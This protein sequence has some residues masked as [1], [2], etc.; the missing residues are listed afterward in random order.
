MPAPGLEADWADNLFTSNGT[1][2]SYM[3]DELK[4]AMESLRQKTSGPISVPKIQVSTL[5]AEYQQATVRQARQAQLILGNWGNI[6]Q[7]YVHSR[8][9]RPPQ[10]GK[11]KE[12]SDAFYADELLHREH[13][14]AAI[15]APAGSGKSTL[16][17]RLT[18]L[19]ANGVTGDIIPIPIDWSQA[20]DA[21][22]A[23]SLLEIAVHDVWQQCPQEQ[24]NPLACHLQ[25]RLEQ[26]TAVALIDNWGGLRALPEELA[27]Q[28]QAAL[29]KWQ[30]LLIFGRYEPD[31]REVEVEPWILTRLNDK[32]ICR[33]VRAWPLVTGHQLDTEALLNQVLMSE[34]LRD[35]SSVPLFLDLLC[36]GST[37]RQTRLVGRW[38]L[39]N[40]ALDHL[41]AK[42]I[43]DDVEILRFRAALARLAWHGY[44]Q[45]PSA[46]VQY[47][48]DLAEIDDLWREKFGEDRKRFL[49][50]A[51][52]RGLLR[53]ASGA[54]LA[55]PHLA[56]QAALAA[57]EWLRTPDRLDTLE[58]VKSK[59]PWAEVIVFAAAR[60]GLDG[61]LTDLDQFLERLCDPGGSDILGTNWL[62]AGQ[63][64]AE[65]GEST[66]EQLD[67]V[68]IGADI[69]QHLV[70]WLSQA[71][72]FTLRDSV[73]A[74][75]PWLRTSALID[76]L[77]ESAQDRRQADLDRYEMIMALGKLG[78]DTAI[79]A[80][81]AIVLDKTERQDIRDQAVEALG[82]TR[83]AEVVSFLKQLLDDE[84]L[85]KAIVDALAIHNTPEAT[86]ALLT[87]LRDD[88]S[89]A[90]Y[91]LHKLSNP[92]LL[93]VFELAI[94]NSTQPDVHVLAAIANIGSDQAVEILKP[95]LHHEEAVIF[96]RATNLLGGMQTPSS[97]QALLEFAEDEQQPH[98]RRYAALTKLPQ[99]PGLWD[100]SRV[101]DLL[102]QPDLLQ[103]AVDDG[104][105]K[106]SEQTNDTSMAVAAG[107]ITALRRTTDTD[108]RLQL[109][110]VLRK[111]GGGNRQSVA[112]ILAH[113]RR[114]ELVPLLFE[115]T[116][117]PDPAIRDEAI[118]GLG[119]LHQG[120]GARHRC[121]LANITRSELVHALENKWPA[122]QLCWTLGESKD[123]GAVSVLTRALQNPGLADYA[124]EAMGKIGGAEATTALVNQWHEWVKEGV[125][126]S[127]RGSF[128]R[129][130][131][132][133]GEPSGVQTIIEIGTSS[134]DY[135]HGYEALRHL[136]DVSNPAAVGV[137]T[138]SLS[139]PDADVREYAAEALGHIGAAGYSEAERAIPKL[140]E[141]ASLTSDKEKWVQDEAVRSIA[142]RFQVIRDPLAAEALLQA[143]GS[144][145]ENTRRVGLAGLRKLARNFVTDDVLRLVGQLVIT[146]PPGT[147]LF[148]A[149]VQT[150]VVLDH[151]RAVYF[152]LDRL[153]R[154]C[155]SDLTPAIAQILSGTGRPQVVPVILDICDVSAWHYLAR[156]EFLCE[157]IQHRPLT[158]SVLCSLCF[159]YNIRIL[160][161]SSVVLPDGRTLSCQDAVKW[162]R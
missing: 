96:D 131:A 65:L 8:L 147:P 33:F 91:A 113:M 156:V 144:S 2:L 150:L 46:N 111:V 70:A 72:C 7:G 68:G 103:D 41:V 53:Q 36:A 54:R 108:A 127:V 35:L 161:D 105:Q 47:T 74:L 151:E 130:L 139:H 93:P 110:K 158:D 134:D 21:S 27:N 89:Y 39:L 123:K 154:R 92:A 155:W 80:L 45:D 145:D 124:I 98:G 14:H 11:G 69:R 152:L 90:G 17:R 25:D 52:K 76:Q 43:R 85:W 87:Q 79:Q 62:L 82:Y 102:L 3:S 9:E 10:P 59:S 50:L 135:L 42:E 16:W 13:V 58:Q 40:Q 115:L 160:P 57:E 125:F 99:E 4:Q 75:L 107:A 137:L 28:L 56:L 128:F 148:R 117:D 23:T 63:C 5:L 118:Y 114:R 49:D 133:S 48:F 109:E 136:R 149:A 77:V 122:N 83:N 159:A 140:I 55:F 67:R 38:A 32:G 29:S 146:E 104:G 141:L 66:R 60:L 15:I 97:S 162:L 1:S 61:R 88:R 34:P 84:D 116:Q 100:A 6:D 129:A 101:I 95:F 157:L 51:Y 64:L 44:R 12:E 94:S 26:G 126:E 22:S 18:A 81:K 24:R 86:Q 143:I 78:G 19:L 37:G 112:Y 30:R 71:Y 119:M 20:Q 106:P 120:L 138:Q 142:E 132:Q 121:E 73:C 31:S 153:P